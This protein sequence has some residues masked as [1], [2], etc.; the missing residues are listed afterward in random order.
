MVHLGEYPRKSRT[1]HRVSRRD[2][3]QR[4]IAPVDRFSLSCSPLHSSNALNHPQSPPHI[5]VTSVMQGYN[6]RIHYL[7]PTTPLGIILKLS[8]E[9]LTETR[10]NLNHLSPFKNSGEVRPQ[11][12]SDFS[13]TVM[14]ARNAFVHGC[15][16]F[17][18]KTPGNL[19]YGK[20]AGK[21]HPLAIIVCVSSY[22]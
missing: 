17:H 18:G 22:K 9:F 12:R 7:G 14:V 16:V 19:F 13:S 15:T 5:F 3:S 11:I 2:Q 10:P 6:L 4:H 1:T 21:T 8:S 20:P